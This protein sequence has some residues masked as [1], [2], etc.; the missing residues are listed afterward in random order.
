MR[1]GRKIGGSVERVED[2]IGRR[3]GEVV[4]R[5]DRVLDEMSGDR[6]EKER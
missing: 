3:S 1:K 2:K 6:E 5:G 4:R